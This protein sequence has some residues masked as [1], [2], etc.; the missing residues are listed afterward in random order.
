[1]NITGPGQP[2]QNDHE[3]LVARQL[4]EWV[5]GQPGTVVHTSH[6]NYAGKHK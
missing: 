6:P 2:R 5:A 4:N 1:M 3:I